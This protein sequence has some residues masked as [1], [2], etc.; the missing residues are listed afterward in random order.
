M[1]NIK[2]FT[3]ESDYAAAGLPATES[4]VA[5]VESDHGLKYDGVNVEV[6]MPKPGDSIYRDAAGDVHFVTK[7]SVRTALLPSGW[8]FIDLYYY[9]WSDEPF[10]DMGLPSGLLWG[11]CDI[12]VTKAS[13]MCD[14]P[15]TNQ[16]SFFSWGNVDGHNPVNNSF[17]NVYNWG[18]V[19]AQDP[20]YEGQPYG[21][22]PGAALEASFAADSGR[23]AARE[24]VGSPWRMP[25]NAN[26]AELF[27]N[28]DYINAEGEIVTAATSIAKTAADKRVYVNG[29]AG[30]YLRSKINGKRLFFAC[31]GYGYGTSW[32]N[33]GSL[34]YYWSSSFL[35][36][37]GARCLNFDSGGVSPQINNNRYYGFA[38]RPVQ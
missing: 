1:E 33:R 23:D 27:A 28:I 5:L 14:T 30:L 8:V 18:G 16:K 35:S 9:G 24:N 17:V 31:S 2:I 26:H 22:T 29:V 32:S 3:N 4:R 7:E 13:K 15:Y 38:V 21:S 20:W 12:D 11:K 36:A 34:G 6:S 10:V 19:N 25:T 37:R